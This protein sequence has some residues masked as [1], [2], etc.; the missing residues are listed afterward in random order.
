MKTNPDPQ[1]ET[2]EKNNTS[3][4]NINP[5]SS[6]L[7][8]TSLK[9][10][11][12]DYTI[13][14]K[15]S[16]NRFCKELR[17]EASQNL[18]EY[19]C[20][21]IVEKK[22][23]QKGINEEIAIISEKFLISENC[24]AEIL[25]INSAQKKF[26]VIPIRH[27]VTRKWNAIIFVH[28][29]KQI[30]QYLN[31][32]NTEPI[33]AKIISSNVNSEEDDYI[34][35]TTMDKIENAFNFTSPEDIQFE[36]DSI[37]ICDQPNTSVF[38]L[39]FIEGLVEQENNTDKIM[40]YIM[41]LYDESSN[42]STGNNNYFTSFNKEN[43]I[44][45]NLIENYINEIKNFY[46]QN[47]NNQINDNQNI[48][49]LINFQQ[50]DE[51]ESEEEALR[52]VERDNEEALKQMEDQDFY[53]NNNMNRPYNMNLDENNM[54]PQTVLGLIQE[55]ED[56]SA[57]DSEQKSNYKNNI[58]NNSIIKKEDINS[59]IE[60]NNDI[61]KDLS[62][63]SNEENN[64]DINMDNNNSSNKDNKDE[65]NE[66]NNKDNIEIKNEINNNN[67]NI[68][69]DKEL[70][71]KENKDINNKDNII[72][73]IDAININNN[74]NKEEDKKELKEKIGNNIIIKK[75]NNTDIQKYIQEKKPEIKIKNE[76][77][78]LIK[79]KTNNNINI[80][81]NNQKNNKRNNNIIQNYRNI[82]S[83][84]DMNK[85]MTKLSNNLD[86]IKNEIIN[87]LSKDIN[88]NKNLRGSHHLINNTSEK[89]KLLSESNSNNENITNN[90]NAY[91]VI[92]LQRNQ[93]YN[94][95]A[96]YLS[97]ANTNKQKKGNKKNNKSK[98]DSKSEKTQKN[99]NNPNNKYLEGNKNINY[100]ENE[101][102]NNII[103][104]SNYN[105]INKNTIGKNKII[106][107][108]TLN[109]NTFINFIE[110]KNNYEPNN[111]NN[112]NND[113]DF[114]N[115]AITHIPDDGITNK[116]IETFSPNKTLSGM[117][118]EALEGDNYL[119]NKNKTV[120]GRSISNL[121]NFSEL[122]PQN[123]KLNLL[124][125]FL[126]G[127]EF[128]NNDNINKGNNNIHNSVNQF[129]PFD[130]NEDN[131]NKN[132]TQ[133]IDIIDDKDKDNNNDNC[134]AKNPIN[135]EKVNGNPLQRR[136]I[137]QLKHRGGPE[138]K[139]TNNNDNFDSFDLLRDY[140]VSNICSLNMENDLNCGC[141]GTDN[142]CNIF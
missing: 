107:N 117:K 32:T 127:N 67:I 96:F 40:E 112:I 75:E 29:E 93:K 92:N 20:Y 137:K 42:N 3:P 21:K 88:K 77:K 74:T 2:E 41:K 84:K 23:A 105:K 140:K 18:F 104:E 70:T 86:K 71:I 81:I 134:I 114:E 6:T 99:N 43:D 129:N 50:E 35:N 46:K 8:F 136:T 135:V 89:L 121:D 7:F 133:F 119:I 38:L 138:K 123:R 22:I 95:S 62:E 24:K 52:L 109:N 103:Y 101:K 85:S 87:N 37:N 48:F 56:E 47:N 9:D 125:D 45:N 102:N 15:S 132:I 61:N 14:L 59:E 82:Q 1:K 16:L 126:F 39:N 76:E 60:N 25:K 65:K 36:V 83:E 118:N 57:E 49:D 94:N 53:Y 142:G 68:N 28:L 5:L 33:V 90:T 80:N 124:N 26:I 55:V 97:K 111:I 64:N 72:E 110:I 12:F 108:E 51:D 120:K 106:I 73:N 122:K 4:K 19:L 30:F 66:E 91:N 31:K 34:L 58:N 128:I 141:A 139:R 115:E 100:I 113:L 78:P 13:S 98:Y 10:S 11:C 116:L 130:I 69:N 131:E 63:V 79:P 54:K 27:A 44:F 17:G